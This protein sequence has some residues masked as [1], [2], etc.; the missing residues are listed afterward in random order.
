MLDAMETVKIGG[1][2]VMKFTGGVE[3][4]FTVQLDPA[5]VFTGTQLS[6]LATYCAQNTLS[7]SAQFTTIGIT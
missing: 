6:Q 5:Q 2:V 4:A 7:L 1:S 3:Q